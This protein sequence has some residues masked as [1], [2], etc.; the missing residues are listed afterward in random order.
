M[1]K[2]VIF[3]VFSNNSRTTYDTL[4]PYTLD[5]EKEQLQKKPFDREKME[6]TS[7][8]AANVHEEQHLCPLGQT[9]IKY[10]RRGV[11]SNNQ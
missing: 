11:Y 2:N 3:Y 4:Y 10:C 7:G 6:E 9:D 8:R 1:I 5:L